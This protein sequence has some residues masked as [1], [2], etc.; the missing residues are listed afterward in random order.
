MSS[1]HLCKA[2]APTEAAA[3]NS[4]LPIKI[5]RIL[6]GGETPP[7]HAPVNIDKIQS[8]RHIGRSIRCKKPTGLTVGFNVSLFC[9]KEGY[10]YP[11]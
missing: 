3:E 4:P 11:F 1:G 10:R 7:L 9:R 8:E 5:C 2:E 6:A